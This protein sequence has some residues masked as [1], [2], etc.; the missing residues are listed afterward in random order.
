[1]ARKAAAEVEDLDLEDFDDAE[2][3]EES[4]AKSKGKGKSKKA[5]E[6]K[7]VSASQLAAHLGAEGKTFRAWVRRKVEA[8]DLKLEREAKT[9]YDF[10]PDFD[11]PQVKQIV[12]L[13]N[14]ESHEKGAGLEAA[15][16]AKEEKA[17]K[18]GT[19]K[20]KSGV[21]GTRAKK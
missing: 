19:S 16:K 14:S 7:G 5:A 6:P 18:S 8:G 9:R 4:S 1:M 10:G 12:E 2:E 17:A 21:K 3:A 15:R 11:S 13:W 20:T